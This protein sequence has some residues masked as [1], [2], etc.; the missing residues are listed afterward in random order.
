MRHPANLEERAVTLQQFR[1]LVR[2]SYRPE[3]IS[4]LRSCWSEWEEHLIVG[5]FLAGGENR[6]R[7][8]QDS[9]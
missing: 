6:L 1:P 7:N 4:S 3:D 9:R 2:T 5:R 8:L